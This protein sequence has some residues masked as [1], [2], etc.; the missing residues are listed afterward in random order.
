M[1]QKPVVEVKNLKVHFP[2]HGGVISK[3]VGTVKA[4][5]RFLFYW[6]K[7]NC[8]IGWRVRLRKNN[9]WTCHDKYFTPHCT[10]CGN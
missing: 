5:W 1:S 6:T 7:R 3:K 8:G 9:R 4:R 10:R 2:I